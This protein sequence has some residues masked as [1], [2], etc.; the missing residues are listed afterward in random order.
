VQ[1]VSEKGV[2]GAVKYLLDIILVV[3]AISVA[4]LPFSLK[5]GFENITWTAGENYWFLVVLLFGTGILAIGMVFELR[6]I[7]CR[8]NE[9]KPFQRQNAT[10]L[11]RIAVMAL[12]ISAAY[13]IKIIF[14]ISF[15]TIVVAIAFLVFG[16]A[17]L[18]FSELFGQAVEVKEE[19]DL[20][21]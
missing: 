13:I 8:I 19:N 3:G 5:W 17:G 11:K 15:L 14:Y 1:I 21:I 18:V 16:L 10:S 12:L 9:H 2:S 6:Q 7:F 20:T 4:G